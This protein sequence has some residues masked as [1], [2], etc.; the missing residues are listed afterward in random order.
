MIHFS[1]SGS[2]KTTWSFL[3]RLS[4]A[5]IKHVSVAS[6]YLLITFGLKSSQTPLMSSSLMS[7][8]D[9][10]CI[11]VWESWPWLHPQLTVSTRTFASTQVDCCDLV[12]HLAK[13][14][15]TAMQQRYA[16]C[17]LFT[18]WISHSCSLTA[19]S[20]SALR[21]EIQLVTHLLFHYTTLHHHYLRAHSHSNDA[22]QLVILC[23]YYLRLL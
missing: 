1:S 17:C 20:H 22:D 11:S 15:S 10:I 12:Q 7:L 5:F 21:I 4:F 13:C 16:H 14:S 19:G 9:P 18:D 8:Q 2:V 6:V 3:Q 23:R